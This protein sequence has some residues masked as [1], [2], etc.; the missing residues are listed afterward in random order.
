LN[1]KKLPKKLERQSRSL[2]ILKRKKMVKK[3]KKTKDKH[4]TLQ[5]EVTQI[6]T[7]G[8]SHFKKSRLMS[9]CPTALPARCSTS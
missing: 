7:I 9:T 6:N 3:T 4:Q 8:A 1:L 2:L 5:M